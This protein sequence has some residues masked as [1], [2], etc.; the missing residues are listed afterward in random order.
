ML[1]KTLINYEK[2]YISNMFLHAEFLKINKLLSRIILFMN[3]KH[4]IY[5]IRRYHNSLNM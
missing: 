4:C 2:E 5:Q 3:K 1:K